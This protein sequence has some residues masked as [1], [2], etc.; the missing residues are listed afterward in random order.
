MAKLTGSSKADTGNRKTGQSASRATAE[1][2][3]K[4]ADGDLGKIQALLF[5]EQSKQ[6]DAELASLESSVTA[7]STRMGSDLGNR[8]AA[9]EKDVNHRLDALAKRI[10]DSLA[11]LESDKVDRKVLADLLTKTATDLRKG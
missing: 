11:S 6:F 2:Q 10:D 9:L 4:F 7:M 1:A 5:G 8:I 3:A